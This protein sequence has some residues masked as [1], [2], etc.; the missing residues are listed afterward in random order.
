MKPLPIPQA[1]AALTLCLGAQALA[2]AGV[3]AGALVRSLPQA[4]NMSVAALTTLQVA[5]PAGAPAAQQEPDAVRLPV[6]CI[7]FTG[8]TRLGR[9]QLL[10]AVAGDI[11]RTLSLTELRQTAERV[12][13]LYRTQGWAVRAELPPQDLT[14]GKVTIHIVDTA[15]AA[16][17]QSRKTLGVMASEHSHASTNGSWLASW[18]DRWLHGALGASVHPLTLSASQADRRAEHPAMDEDPATPTPGHKLS[19]PENEEQALT[20]DGDGLS[21]KLAFGGQRGSAARAASQPRSRGGP[22][23]VHAHVVNQGIAPTGQLATAELRAPLGAGRPTLAAF[24]DTGWVGRLGA[25]GER[26][27]LALTGLGLAL[28]WQHPSGLALRAAWARRLHTGLQ[29]DTGGAGAPDA[30]VARLWLGVWGR[31]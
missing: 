1:V 5:D 22:H 9:A 23:G 25:S 2:W 20:S 17:Q 24:V 8:N 21:V 4:P 28:A 15:P 16:A 3:E 10:P 14:G 7:V 29:A 11:G 27:R 6:H 26:Q 31:L 13:A 18:L 30:D 12:A 19:W